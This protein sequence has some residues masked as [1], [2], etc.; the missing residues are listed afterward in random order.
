M[1]FLISF[2]IYSTPKPSNY[3]TLLEFA[4]KAIQYVP[5]NSYSSRFILH[6][7]SLF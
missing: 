4:Y 6:A 2:G 5:I 3:V 7:Q 1:S